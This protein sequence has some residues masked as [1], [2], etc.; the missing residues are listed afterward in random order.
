[1]TGK[2]KPP[3]VCDE[4]RYDG[5]WH[6]IDEGPE[7]QPRRVRCNN[8]LA[9]DLLEQAQKLTEEARAQAKEAA[10]RIVADAA[11]TRYLFSANDLRKEL[12]AAQVPGSVVGGAFTWAKEQGLITKTEQRVMSDQE[13]TRHGI[14]VW[15]SL[16]YRGAVSA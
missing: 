13:S 6:Y 3:R 5:G 8:Y 2:P 12:D 4:C 16:R 7:R 11:E 1:M 15:R 10:R 9:A 14:D